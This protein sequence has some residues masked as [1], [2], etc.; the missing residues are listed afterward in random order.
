MPDAVLLRIERLTREYG[1]RLA[2]SDVSQM[3][4][5]VRGS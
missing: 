4:A 5:I 2:V 1:R 3:L